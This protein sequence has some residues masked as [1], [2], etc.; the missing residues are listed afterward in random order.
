MSHKSFSIIVPTYNC[1]RMLPECV[2]S[3]R[4]QTY[5]QEAYEIIVVD[6]NS[7]DETPQVIQRLNQQ[8]GKEI[9]YALEKRP[10]L[11]EARH[12]GARAAKNEI[13]AYTDDDV[14]A[15]PGWLAGLARA[16]DELEA[17]CVGGKILI[18][19]DKEPPSWVLPYQ[20]VMGQIDHGPT[21]KILN[22]GQ[23]IYGGNFSIR[24][25]RLFEIGGFNPDQ[26]GEHLIGDGEIGLCDKIHT[27]GWRMAWAPDALVWHL[28]SAAKNAT[29]AD[30]KRRYANNGVATVYAMY[31]SGQLA[32]DSLIMYAGRMWLWLIRHKTMALLHSFPRD[33]AYYSHKL[34]ESHYR[35]RIECALRLARDA[36]Y[37]QLA[38][39]EDWINP[40][41]YKSNIH[42]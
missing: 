12:A 20:G 2:A 15:D 40:D 11:M 38:M 37:R 17:D 22:P 8:S 31:K 4:A 33:R 27:A 41:D 10:G 21:L 7:T 32:T 9:R 16:Y 13:L 3:L 34:A 29:L 14:V 26:I 18:R 19:W 42:I 36:G 6:N 25:S 30:L 39:R 1:C 5:P 24:R 23:Y 35:G 28:Q